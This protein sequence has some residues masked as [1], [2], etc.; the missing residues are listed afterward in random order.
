MTFIPP[1]V[2]E[3]KKN[4]YWNYIAHPV[5]KAESTIPL[6]ISSAILERAK[7]LLFAP[8]N[9]GF[10][11]DVITRQE[12]LT[13]TPAEMR[14]N[15]PRMFE[16]LRLVFWGK[17]TKYMQIYGLISPMGHLFVGKLAEAPTAE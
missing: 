7:P 9:N 2:P 13:Q 5:S 11:Y 4:E 12:G 8:E 14:A 1:I 16:Q 6:G 15:D 3:N 17:F 10:W